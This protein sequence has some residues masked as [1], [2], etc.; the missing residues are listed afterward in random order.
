MAPRH[1]TGSPARFTQRWLLPPYDN[2]LSRHAGCEAEHPPGTLSIIR[3]E[4]LPPYVSLNRLDELV[5]RAGASAAIL[6][7]ISVG[8][9]DSRSKDRNPDGVPIPI[10]LDL[11][12]RATHRG[13]RHV[14]VGPISRKPLRDVLT[15]HHGLLPQ[16]QAWLIRLRPM[17]SP[18]V[19]RIVRRAL[20]EGM[21]DPDG[22]LAPCFTNRHQRKLLRS[23]QLPSPGALR[24]I[25]RVLPP[26]LRLQRSSGRSA[27]AIARRSGFESERGLRRAIERACGCEAQQ[28][29]GMWG[30]EG[31]LGPLLLGGDD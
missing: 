8:E 2:P 21:D 31:I 23:A 16:V 25:G 19:L 5:R 11:V 30:W 6:E 9:P 1:Q 7:I 29:E 24:R 3:A 22:L 15:N 13:I 20:G 27:P 12:H 14:S 17:L 18:K 26:I 28:A 4:G 10:L